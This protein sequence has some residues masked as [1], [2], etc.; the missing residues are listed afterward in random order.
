MIFVYSCTL[1][2]DYKYMAWR[3]GTPV[4]AELGNLG[5]SNEE[6]IRGNEEKERSEKGEWESKEGLIIL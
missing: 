3:D 4:I 2:F 5:G 1:C 6:E